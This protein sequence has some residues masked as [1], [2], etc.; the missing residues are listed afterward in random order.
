MIRRRKTPKHL[1]VGLDPG[2]ASLGVCVWDLIEERCITLAVLRTQKIRSSR[3]M[4]EDVSTRGLALGRGLRDLVPWEDVLAVCAESVSLVRNA[5][6]C[7]KVGVGWGVCIAQAAQT[8]LPVHEVR[9][10]DVRRLLGLPGR[11]AKADIKAAVLPYPGVEAALD[12]SKLPAGQH[13]HCLDAVAA[14]LAWRET[15]MG[16]ML[17]SVLSTR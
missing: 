15:S 12:A 11:A 13:E 2:F 17:A 9:P 16:A 3:T 5:S 4:S 10:Q 8:G 6:A 7:Y 14:V 1:L